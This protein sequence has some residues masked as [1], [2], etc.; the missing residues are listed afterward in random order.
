MDGAAYFVQLHRSN[1]RASRAAADDDAAHR[2]KLTSAKQGAAATW[3]GTI[4]SLVEA[5]H[6]WLQTYPKIRRPR[7][8]CRQ[9]LSGST[10]SLAA[11]CRR[12]TSTLSKGNQEPARRRSVSSS[13]YRVRA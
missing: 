5:G 11:E 10:R 9:V 13:C 4:R 6:A 1:E 12:V 2:G 3:R 7:L 8:G